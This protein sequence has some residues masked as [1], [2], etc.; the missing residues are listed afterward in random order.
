MK[1]LT[2]NE[3]GDLNLQWVEGSQVLSNSVKRRLATNPVSYAR[4]V[5]TLTG[6]QEVGTTFG[7]TLNQYIAQPENDLNQAEINEIV[8]GSLAE[9]SRVTLKT[10]SLQGTKIQVVFTPSNS[11]DILI[12]S[13]T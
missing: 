3:E 2:F 1:D 5:R 11:Q 13:I 9:D 10:V 4:I 8:A 6:T 12:A 7:S